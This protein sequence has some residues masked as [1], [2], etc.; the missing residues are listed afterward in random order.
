MLAKVRNQLRRDYAFPKAS[1]SKKSAKFGIMAVYSDEPVEKPAEV[2]DTQIGLTGL[3]C[4]GYGS[5]ICVTANAGFIAAQQ[6]L[7]IL[8]SP[9]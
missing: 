2:C 1:D 7:Q 8:V 5:S 4:A 9:Q 6:A 3:H